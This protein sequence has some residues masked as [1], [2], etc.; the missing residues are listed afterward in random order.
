MFGLGHLPFGFVFGSFITFNLYCSNNS[1]FL[2]LSAHFFSQPC[3]VVSPPFLYLVYDK[4]MDNVAFR[5]K[6]RARFSQHVLYTFVPLFRPK[7]GLVCISSRTQPDVPRCM[8][9]M[10]N[11]RVESRGH[12]TCY[13]YGHGANLTSLISLLSFLQHIRQ[14]RLSSYSIRQIGSSHLRSFPTKKSSCYPAH[15]PSRL[16]K[17]GRI[18]ES[19]THTHTHIQPNVP[20]SDPDSRS[21]AGTE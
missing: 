14:V 1:T 9:V 18:F 17:A 4:I 8:D 3:V 5:P 20:R 21:E 7:D 19:H 16:K 11:A 6:R 12:V 2:P 10:V 15:H 13:W